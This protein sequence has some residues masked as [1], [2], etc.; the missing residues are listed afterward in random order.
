[1]DYGAERELLLVGDDGVWCV[2]F[3]TDWVFTCMV[4]GVVLD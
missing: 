3:L 2:V 1:M 4:V